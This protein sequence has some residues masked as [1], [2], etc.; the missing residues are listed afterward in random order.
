M[1]TQLSP[2]LSNLVVQAPT[3]LVYLC[4]LIAALVMWSR[5]PR[6]ALLVF[7]GSAV[8]LLTSISFPVIQQFVI[9]GGGGGGGRGRGASGSSVAELM[10]FVGL[11][12]SV[13][14]A[15]GFGLVVWAAFVQRREPEAFTTGFPMGS[16]A[17]SGPPPLPR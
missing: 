8:L 3:L 15:T 2:L 1:V 6:P 16:P 11:L 4:G 10:Q 12:A 9:S 5:F 7:L 17:A 14:R 13:L